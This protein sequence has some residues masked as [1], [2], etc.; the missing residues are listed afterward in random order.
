MHQTLA[1]DAHHKGAV[2]HGRYSTGL[3]LWFGEDL[4]F[5]ASTARVG[6]EASIANRG[7]SS[8]W[9]PS[10]FGEPSSAETNWDRAF[11]VRFRGAFP[12]PVGRYELR[13]QVS[14][15][16]Q[17]NVIGPDFRELLGL[18]SVGVESAE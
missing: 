5:L 16:S 15:T 2:G 12:M 3:C 1:A 10:G 9:P 13:A 11:Y 8:V 14:M 17:S 7:S 6:S 4:L 18:L